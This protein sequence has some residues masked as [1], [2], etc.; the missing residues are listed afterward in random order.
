[1]VEMLPNIYIYITNLRGI[2]VV[3]IVFNFQFQWHTWL[4]RGEQVIL[5]ANCIAQILF[6]LTRRSGCNKWFD[7]TSNEQRNRVPILPRADS[8][9][10]IEG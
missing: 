2:D 8:I 4:L 6:L 3:I 7:T 5:H 10:K 1:M 9:I